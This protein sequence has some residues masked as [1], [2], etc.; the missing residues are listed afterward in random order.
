MDRQTKAPRWERVFWGNAW[1]I[2]YVPTEINPADETSMGFYAHEIENHDIWLNGPDF[3]LKGTS[4]WPPIQQP[5]ISVV[6]SGR[7]SPN[8]NLR[9]KVIRVNGTER[10]GK[11]STDYQ[12]VLL[13]AQRMTSTPRGVIAS[14]SQLTDV[15]E[16]VP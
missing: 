11:G 4:D 15:F 1:T 14:S 16:R 9:I 6:T 10:Y 7:L 5:I 3:L 12:I 2:L 13:K 8:A